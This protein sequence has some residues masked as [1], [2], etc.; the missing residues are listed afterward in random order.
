MR[1]ASRGA[2]ATA[3]G[4]AH[5]WA[6]EREATDVDTITIS[7]PAVVVRLIAVALPTTA[8]SGLMYYL[9]GAV[10]AIL[11]ATTAI[12]ALPALYLW[13]FTQRPPH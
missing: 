12:G 2:V 10:P 3:T 11:A 9:G 13:L 4:M 5:R 6:Q 7:I 1:S 8:L